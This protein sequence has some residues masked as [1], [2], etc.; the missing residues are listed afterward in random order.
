VESIKDTLHL[1][2]TSNQVGV[3]DLAGP[4]GIYSI[5][6]RMISGGVLTLLGWIGLLSVNIGVL[7]L[8]PIP[9]L[10]GG[11]LVFLSIEALTR[12]KVSRNIENRIHTAMYFLL[13]VLFAYVTW[14]DILRLFHLK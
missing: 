11:R 7:N 9:A 10:D 12:Q 14:N 13:L 6:S 5:T 1:L 2:F 8:L 4:V 3:D